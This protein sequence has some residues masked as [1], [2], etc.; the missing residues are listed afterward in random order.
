M[1]TPH[2]NGFH[3]DDIVEEIYERLDAPADVPELSGE[4]V[5]GVID[6]DSPFD[7]CRWIVPTDTYAARSRSKKCERSL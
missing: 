1:S 7:S 3:K 2:T 4:S 6:I 5:E